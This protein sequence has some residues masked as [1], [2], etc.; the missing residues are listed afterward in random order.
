MSSRKHQVEFSI[1]Y[2]WLPIYFNECGTNIKCKKKS[3]IHPNVN[4]QYLINNYD[5]NY[6]YN[7]KIHRM[8]HPFYITNYITNFM[9]LIVKLL[10][11]VVYN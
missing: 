10:Y 11:F 7:Y 4:N 3:F 6:V 8:D 9:R 5:I 2:L 1:W